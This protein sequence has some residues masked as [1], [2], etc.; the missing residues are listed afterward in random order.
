M[1]VLGFFWRGDMLE[2]DLVV[3]TDLEKGTEVPLSKAVT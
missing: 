2:C 3:G 1:F